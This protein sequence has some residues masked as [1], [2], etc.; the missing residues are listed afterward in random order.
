MS[1]SKYLGIPSLP[2][3]SNTSVS[4]KLENRGSFPRMGIPILKRCTW[5]D[6]K[7]GDEYQKICLSHLPVLV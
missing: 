2:W 1:E 6:P 7:E 3:P 4:D 5:K